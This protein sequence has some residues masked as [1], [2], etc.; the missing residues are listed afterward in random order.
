MERE[1]FEEKARERARE[2]D[3]PLV[4]SG[5][6]YD[7]SL[8]PPRMINGAVAINGYHPMNGPVP[9]IIKPAPAPVVVARC[10]P[11]V[12][13]LLHSETYFRYIEH[14]R[15]D[16]PFISDWPKQLKASISNPSNLSSRALPSQWLLNNSPGLYNNVYEAL[17]SMRDH[18]WS[19][20]I[21][22]RNVLSDEWWRCV[23]YLFVCYSGMF[24]V[25]TDCREYRFV[26]HSKKWCLWSIVV[27]CSFSLLLSFFFFSFSASC[28]YVLFNVFFFSSVRNLLTIIQRSSSNSF[29]R[30]FVLLLPWYVT[31]FIIYILWTGFLNVQ[32]QHHVIR[33]LQHA[34]SRWTT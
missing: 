12:Q 4:N 29:V 3:T 17:W 7:P 34:F 24:I 33:K 5:I 15:N 21:R 13:R 32:K 30:S 25:W 19:D 10:P 8:P 16:H 23:V 18:M 22:V 11:R 31:G 6:T 28:L 14:L 2:Q 20:V 26:H 9:I 27:E 1:K